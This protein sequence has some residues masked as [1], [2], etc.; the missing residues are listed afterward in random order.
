MA[1]AGGLVLVSVTLF[2]VKEKLSEVF[3]RDAQLSK[4]ASV[5]LPLWVEAI[6]EMKW[7]LAYLTCAGA[8][9]WLGY[10]P[11]EW[12]DSLA[13][14]G[15]YILLFVTFAVDFVSP[16]LFRHRHRYGVIFRLLMRRPLVSLV[17]G[18]TFAA[19][20]ILASE[21][22]LHGRLD[23]IGSW[24]IWAPIVIVLIVEVVAIVWAC[25]G[26]TY[27][28][29]QLLEEAKTYSPTHPL[30]SVSV[31]SLIGLVLFSLSR[32]FGGAAVSLY[33]HSR[34]LR[35]EFSVEWR[36]VRPLMP[37]VSSLLS[38]EVDTGFG[39]NVG[40][41]NPT[42]G[43]IRFD[44]GRIELIHDDVVI[45][46]GELPRVE[47]TAGESQTRRIEV[48]VVLELVDILRAEELMELDGWSAIV[49]LQ[50]TD[51]TEFPIFL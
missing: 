32:L 6:E 50:L 34:L 30:V 39:F 46:D 45:G 23:V 7:L 35:C 26:G 38:G 17:F 21:L 5:P 40:I 12:R 41:Y 14:C 25:I 20:P 1:V 8:L 16:I 42:D 51:G 9:F 2:P 28:G 22:F 15:S 11:G 27:L 33:E 29:S 4:E 44:R 43:P 10:Y 49:H 3:E 31:W 13:L 36:S 24:P 48:D 37:S 47:L 19:A 18:A